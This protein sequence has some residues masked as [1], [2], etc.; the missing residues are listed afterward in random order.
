MAVQDDRSHICNRQGVELALRRTLECAW[1]SLCQVI[2]VSGLVVDD[3]YLTDGT[4]QES[5]LCSG[6]GVSAFD[7][8]DVERLSV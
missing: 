2:A 1:R 6:I 5:V 4:L 8:A 3:A 7:S